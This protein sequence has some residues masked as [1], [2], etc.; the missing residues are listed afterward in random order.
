MRRN[1]FSR[2]VLLLALVFGGFVRFAPAVLAGFPL[3]DGGMFA[4]MVDD[5]ARSGWALPAYTT[6]N[7]GE[8]PYAYPPLG[9]YLGRLLEGLLDVDSTFVALWMPPFFATL[10]IPVFYLLA[11]RLL[12]TRFHAAL[13]ALFFALMPRAYSWFIEGGG[14]TR[15]PGQVFLLLTLLAIVTLYQKGDRRQVWWAGLWGG[16]A[17]LSHPEA[18]LHTAFSCFFFWLAISRSHDRFLDSALVAG[19]AALAASP[20]WGTV[21]LRHGLEPILS[22]MATGREW[23]AVFH[24]VFFSFTEEPYLALAAVLGLLGLAWSLARRDWL[25]PLWLALP[26]F[27]E[28]RSAYLLAALPLSMLAARGLADVLFAALR[29]EEQADL[30]APAERWA[31]LYVFLYLLFSSYAFDW[32]VSAVTVSVQDREAMRW[33]REN[34]PAGARFLVLSGSH[35]VSYDPLPE[36]FP[37]LTGRESLFTVQGREWT[38]GED[39]SDAVRAAADLQGCLRESAECILGQAA[40][41]PLDYIYLSRVLR[42]QAFK[43]LDPPMR[44]PYAEQGLRARFDVIY[45]SDQVLIFRAGD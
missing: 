6:F 18:A 23:L 28:G 8:I 27:V 44:F 26:F 33:V 9:F 10:S 20:W 45:E 37:A 22:A 16:L 4:A 30:P 35:S 13:A 34:T 17:I 19:L 2:L 14:I 25:L 29:A 42:T 1:D 11:A 39:F 24:L 7:A 40:G 41:M 3:N 36:W 31:F 12:P 15:S 5:L 21:L 43:P 32:Q 38:L